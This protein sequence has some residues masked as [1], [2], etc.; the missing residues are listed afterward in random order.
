MQKKNQNCFA[1]ELGTKI[2]LVR[3]EGRSIQMLA[4]FGAV[5]FFFF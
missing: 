1:T 4:R 3:W 5:K 2:P